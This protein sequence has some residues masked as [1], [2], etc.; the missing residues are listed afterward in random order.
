MFEEY[1]TRVV[2][3]S[4]GVLAVTSPWPAGQS[5]WSFGMRRNDVRESAGPGLGSAKVEDLLDLV[6]ADQLRSTP[7][8]STLQ[9]VHRNSSMSSI[10]KATL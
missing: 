6:H 5:R 1:T 4:I 8:T 3:R 7:T 10:W 9:P 2:C